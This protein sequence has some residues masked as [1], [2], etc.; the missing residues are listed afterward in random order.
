[1]PTDAQDNPDSSDFDP[2]V[3]YLLAGLR[4]SGSMKPHMCPISARKNKVAVGTKRP[5]CSQQQTT[6][7]FN[8]IMV[9]L[10]QPYAL[11]GT[12]LLILGVR[13]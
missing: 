5:T 10:G 12:T 11:Q 8:T 3:A 7:H 4:V 1:M 9:D 13:D 6:M 2:T